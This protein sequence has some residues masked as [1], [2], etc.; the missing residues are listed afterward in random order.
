MG[1]QYVHIEYG[2]LWLLL[3]LLKNC[4]NLDPRN[5][6]HAIPRFTAGIICGPHRGSFS[7]RD[8][9]RSNLG[10]ICG[11]GSFA[12]L[13]RSQSVANL[14]KNNGG[15][16]AVDRRKWM[17]ADSEMSIFGRKNLRNSAFQSGKTFFYLFIQKELLCSLCVFSLLLPETSVNKLNNE[18]DKPKQSSRANK[19]NTFNKDSDT[20]LWWSHAKLIN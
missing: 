3:F 9:L 7:V 12:A 19:S 20:S 2:W 5:K 17:Y 15:S 10:I 1:I 6:L 4:G 16:G 18:R 8:H 13:Y 14:F 11:R